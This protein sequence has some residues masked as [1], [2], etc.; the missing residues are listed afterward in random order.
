MQWRDTT[1]GRVFQVLMSPVVAILTIVLVLLA[2]FAYLDD[3]R[4]SME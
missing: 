2:P 3:H 4:T 1:R